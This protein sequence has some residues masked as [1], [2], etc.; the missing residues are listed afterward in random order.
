MKV[1][2]FLFSVALLTLWA[3]IV[4][5]WAGAAAWDNWQP[6]A[7]WARQAAC[8]HKYETRGLPAGSW[9]AWHD[10]RNP[11]SRGGMQFIPSTWRSVGGHGDPAKASKQEQLYRAWILYT[12]SG[13]SWRQWTTSTLCGLR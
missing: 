10:T 4:A 11:Q 3:L 8:I 5:R 1:S 12:R 7:W 6:P 13:H 9:A 2:G